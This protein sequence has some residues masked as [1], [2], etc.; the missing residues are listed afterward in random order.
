M[1]LLF[2]ASQSLRPHTQLPPQSAFRK[3]DSGKIQPSL[4]EV[5]FLMG[6]SAVLTHGAEK[7]GV[8]N[9]HQATKQDQQRIVD[10]L[11]RHIYAHLQ[12]DVL[13]DETGLLHLHHAACNLMMLAHHVEKEV[14]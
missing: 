5:D 2:M 11:L 6:M 1:H 3:S 9:Y 13:D 10:A 8:H 14:G 4:I 12:G 7:Y